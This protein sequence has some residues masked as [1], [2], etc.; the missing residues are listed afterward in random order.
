MSSKA[1]PMDSLI[2]DEDLSKDLLLS[3]EESNNPMTYVV[4]QLTA[5]EAVLDLSDQHLGDSFVT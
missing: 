2:D 5:E 4:W 3:S 1:Q